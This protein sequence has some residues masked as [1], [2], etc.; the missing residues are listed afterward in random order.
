M[1]ELTHELVVD[2]VSEAN[3]GRYQYKYIAQKFKVKPQMVS[4]LVFKSNKNKNYL[5]DLKIKEIE[6]INSRK[7]VVDAANTIWN[8]GGNIWTS[9]QVADVVKTKSGQKMATGYVS[10]VL[11]NDL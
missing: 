5:N 6:R 2:I 1:R 11:R 9:Q 10:K 8:D 3:L 7:A 4:R